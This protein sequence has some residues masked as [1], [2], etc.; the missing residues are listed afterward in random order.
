MR[1]NLYFI[2]VSKSDLME[3]ESKIKHFEING[4]KS[5]FVVANM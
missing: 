2:F 1:Q 5:W 4:M 3:M